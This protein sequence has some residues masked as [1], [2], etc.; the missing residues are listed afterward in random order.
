MKRFTFTMFLAVIIFGG[1]YVRGYR[2]ITLEEIPNSHRPN[3]IF[4]SADYA[5]QHLSEP[6]KTSSKITDL[7]GEAN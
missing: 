5:N 4:L 1:A 2:L 6:T 7:F 3:A